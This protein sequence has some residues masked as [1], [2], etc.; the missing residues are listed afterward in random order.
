MA[1][2]F[3][4][5]HWYN[6]TRGK[7]KF[8]PRAKHSP[9]STGVVGSLCILHLFPSLPSL[10]A[11]PLLVPSCFSVET[12]GLETTLIVSKGSWDHVRAPPGVCVPSPFGN[13]HQ[14]PREQLKLLKISLWH[15]SGWYNR[16][17]QGF[18]PGGGRL[19]EWCHG[20]GSQVQLVLTVA[21]PRGQGLN[22]LHTGTICPHCSS[23]APRLFPSP[24]TVCTAQGAW[25]VFAPRR[26]S[27]RV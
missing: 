11:S 6:S 19:P 21:G 27:R 3:P 22:L 10:P 26:P 8:K 1:P 25:G 5:W 4:C 16:P 13:L 12:P 14:C 2:S 7:Y 17:H 15:Q 18:S 9:A 20:C 23:P 24:E